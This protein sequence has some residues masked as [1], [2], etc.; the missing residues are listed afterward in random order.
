MADDL[1]F[2]DFTRGEKLRLV[3]LHARM[4]KRGLAGDTVDLSDLKRKVERIE[5][6]AER[7]KN[8]K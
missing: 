6:T 1:T 4:A 3:A 8:G 2:R 7:R 5:K